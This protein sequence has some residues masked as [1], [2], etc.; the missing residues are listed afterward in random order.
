MSGLSSQNQ[1]TLKEVLKAINLFFLC[2]LSPWAWLL[3]FAFLV[4]GATL[5]SLLGIV[6]PSWAMWLAFLGVP[7]GA[8]IEIF[9]TDG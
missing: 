8:A 9:S 3:S 4:F 1:I 7:L 6:L 2:A 5:A